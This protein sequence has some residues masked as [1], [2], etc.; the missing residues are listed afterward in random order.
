VMAVLLALTAGAAWAIT[1]NP[2]K[3][4]G[5]PCNGTDV[6]DKIIG[7]DNR[8][9]IGARSGNDRVLT[10]GGSD[11][12]NGGPGDDQVY[13]ED[14]ADT[15]HGSLGNDFLSGA[16]GPDTIF[17]GPDD[18]RARSHGGNDTINVEGDSSN[19]DF[20]NCG[21]GDSDTARVDSNDVVDNTVAETLV[22]N[23]AMSCERIF[24]NGIL[25]PTGP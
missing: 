12:A 17:G 13:G 1:Y 15:L 16:D 4:S 23:T 24:V 21:A 9:E 2:V 7:T 25:I 20:V 8:D 14:G 19:R 5:N 6:A 3:C 22:V 11:K 18:D 10:R